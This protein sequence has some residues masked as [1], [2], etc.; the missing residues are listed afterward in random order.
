ME[1]QTQ[2][3]L[4]ESLGAIPGLLDVCLGALGALGG[5]VCALRVPSRVHHRRLGQSGTVV[6]SQTVFVAV[7]GPSTA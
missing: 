2:G 7:G 1:Y 6:S 3:V 5:A 4:E